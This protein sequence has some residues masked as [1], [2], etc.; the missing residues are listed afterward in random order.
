MDPNL[1]HQVESTVHKNADQIICEYFFY[2]FKIICIKNANKTNKS[3]VKQFRGKIYYF[4][5]KKCVKENSILFLE[6]NYFLTRSNDN[7]MH[8]YD[9]IA[10]TNLQCLIQDYSIKEKG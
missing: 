2:L 5:S 10:Y 9:T 6:G 4:I 8:L 7:K 3:N 1:S